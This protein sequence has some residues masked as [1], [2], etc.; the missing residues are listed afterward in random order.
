MLSVA[1]RVELRDIAE[2]VLIWRMVHPKWVRDQ[3]WEP[4]VTSTVVE[5]KGQRLLLDPLAGAQK[6]ERCLGTPG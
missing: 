5:S 4:I 3:E 6:R 2:G 1:E